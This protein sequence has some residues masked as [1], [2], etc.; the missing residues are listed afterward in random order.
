MNHISG[1]NEK[2]KEAALVIEGPL[3]IVAGAGAGKT[4]TITSRIINLIENNIAPENILAITFTNKAAKEMRERI[5]HALAEKQIK[6][7]PFIATFHSLCVSILRENAPLVDRSRHFSIYDESDA[8]GLIKESIKE[9]DL[10]PKQFDAKKF[11]GIISREKGNFVTRKDYELKVGSYT[12]EVVLKIWEKYEK[13][14]KTEE[15]FDFDDLLLETVL[16]LKKNKNIREVYQNRFKY[17]HIDEYQDTNE[18]QYELSKLLVSDKHNICVVG[19][20]DQNIYSWRGAKIK[21]MLHFEKDFPEAKIVFLE[22]NYRST[23]TILNAAN[24]IIK[25]NSLRADKTLFTNNDTGEPVSIYEAYTEIDEAEFVVEKAEELMKN[26]VNPEE[27]AVLF[28]ANFQSRVLEE[29]FLAKQMP[30]HVLGTRFFDRKEVKDILSYLRAARNPE[31]LGDIKRIIN[32]PTRGIGKTTLDKLFAGNKNSLPDK[33]RE[34]IENFYQMLSRVKTF[35]QE[36]NVS[37]TVKYLVQETGIED[38]LKAG[39]MSDL[40]R[41]EN[42]KELVTLAT[43]YDGL[44][45]EEALEKLLDDAAL[46]SDQDSLDGNKSGVRLMTVHAAKGLEFSYVF[47]VGLEQ[48]LFPHS[49]R[50][51]DNTDSREEE[52]RLFYV[53]LTRARI[54][55]YLSYATIRT[56]YG[57]RQVAT[58]SEFLYD[59]PENLTDRAKREGRENKIIY[60]D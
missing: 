12:E 1:L 31:S 52:R 19:D 21:N 37:A 10:D 9:M 33:M 58:P 46:A 48:D 7:T 18:V 53:A 4:K 3:L 30:Y 32:F 6:R 60:I 29:E 27:I 54:K 55:L 35:S 26:S 11:K 42:I 24:E 51:N 49:R 5:L 2:Q 36:N 16:M 17:I 41:F 44:P 34:K 40:E 38:Y 50:E 28:R 57:V 20:T 13:K 59:I 14:L 22:Q 8:I 15:A 43:K 47:I 25:K 39:D 45:Q 23:K 56:L